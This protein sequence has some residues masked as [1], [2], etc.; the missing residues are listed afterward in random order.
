MGAERPRFH[1][2]L[3][4]AR[5]RASAWALKRAVSATAAPRVRHHSPPQSQLPLHGGPA[6]YRPLAAPDQ[7]SKKPRPEPA[8]GPEKG[9][10]PE[11]AMPSTS[12]AADTAVPWP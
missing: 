9:R 10:L 7:D 2:Q 1:T 6:T 4:Y 5:P 11:T 3:P 12:T 8:V